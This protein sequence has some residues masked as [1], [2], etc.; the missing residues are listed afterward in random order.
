VDAPV[1]DHPISGTRDFAWLVDQFVEA[2]PGVTHALVVSLDGLQL[3]ASRMV[4]RDLGDQLA[5]LT[6][7]LLSMADR[8][9][10]LLDLGDT[11]YMT[12]RLPHGHLLFIRVGESAGLAVA[13]AI[14]CDLRVVAYHMTQFV[15]A[16]GHVLTPQL[17]N[18]LTHVSATSSESPQG[19]YKV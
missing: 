15:S 16:V 13:A 3:A 5:A 14:G 9:A 2:A 19:N 6:A 1:I 10:S 4:P 12:I 17:R 7:G 11:E 8:S 18:E